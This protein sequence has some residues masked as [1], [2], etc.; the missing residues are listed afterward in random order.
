MWT[1]CSY[2]WRL[3][4][5]GRL[6]PLLG[7]TLRRSA[8][9]ICAKSVACAREQRYMMN[10]RR[11][12]SSN[13]FEVPIG[14]WCVGKKAKGQSLTRRSTIFVINDSARKV[15]LTLYSFGSFASVRHAIGFEQRVASYRSAISSSWVVSSHSH[16]MPQRSPNTV[17]RKQPI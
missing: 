5:L 11:T 15:F 3:K 14:E 4:P 16:N 9:R 2:T 12:V 8:C 13:V 6:L 1:L 10:A 7:A 17:H